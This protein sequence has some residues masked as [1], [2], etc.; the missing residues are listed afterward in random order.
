[1]KK[2]SQLIPALA[3]T[4][5]LPL[6]GCHKEPDPAQKEACEKFAK[7]LAE[8]VQKEQGEQVPKEQVDAMVE[9]TV[10]QCLA[11]PPEAEEMKCAMA[12]TDTK[13]MKACDPK[14]EVESEANKDDQQG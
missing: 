5:L 7:H 11:A 6:V 12:A 8:V 1:M 9:A 14:A 3:L 4:A 13:A 2:I 10:G